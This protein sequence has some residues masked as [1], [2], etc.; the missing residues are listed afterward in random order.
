MCRDAPLRWGI[1]C[2][3]S[4]QWRVTPANGVCE[5][6]S[7]GHFRGALGRCYPNKND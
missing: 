6:E 1:R 5:K 7:L 2:A 4:G 3:S